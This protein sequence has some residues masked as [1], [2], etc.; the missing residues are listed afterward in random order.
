MDL[1]K[2]QFEILEK[3]ATG[4]NLS[5]RQLKESA[6]F[7]LGLVNK[8][9]QE[10]KEKNAVENGRITEEGFSLLEPYRVRRAVFLAAGLGARLAPIT[11]NTPK[12]L[13]RVKDQRIIDTLLDACYAAGIKEIYVVRGYLA[14]QFD[15]LLYKYPSVTFLE[16]PEYNEGNNIG[17]AMAARD[18]LS[19]AYVFEADILLYNPALIRPYHYSSNFLGIRQQRCDDWCCRVRDGIIREELLGAEGDDVYRMVG[20]SYWDKP[21]GEKLSRDIAGVYAGPGGK[22]R[23]W[24]QVPLVYRKDHYRVALRECKSSDLDE[25]DTFK[26]LKTIDRTYSI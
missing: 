16:N 3:L 24:E 14:E 6:G 20:I 12:P 11:F 10:L 19:N 18:Y 4:K 13:I 17:S 15:Q 8:I 5:Q 1:S 22:E 25:I 23:Y 26:E 9:M 2:K 21:D 7:S